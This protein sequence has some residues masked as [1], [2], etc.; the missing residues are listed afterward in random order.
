MRQKLTELQEKMNPLW[1]HQ[2]RVPAE[3]FKTPLSEK[4][5]SSKQ[6]THKINISHEQRYQ[7]PPQNTD[8]PNPTI[9]KRIIHHN[10]VGFIPGMKDW[11]HLWNSVDVIDMLEKKRITIYI[12]SI[13]SQSRS[14]QK[15][16]K[17]QLI[18]PN[19]HS[20]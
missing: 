3:D 9:I 20:Q 16:P 14:Y 7:N 2:M 4:N 5:R 17:K 12:L 8:K 19:T 18:R 11:F 10:K 6:Q 15:M 13:E 1:I